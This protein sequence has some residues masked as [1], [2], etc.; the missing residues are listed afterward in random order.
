[1]MIDERARYGRRLRRLRRSARRWSVAAGVLGGASVVLA[2]Y[3]GLSPIDAFWVGAAGGSVV[4]AGWRWV[5]YREL[6]AQPAPPTLDPAAVADRARGWA[7][8]FV[9][10]LPWGREALSGVRRHANRGRLRGSAV[11]PGWIRL[12][13]AAVGLGGLPLRAGEPARTVVLDAAAAEKGLR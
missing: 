4:L 11:K 9:V 5:D 2:P 6:A 7:E 1:V 13:R 12:D 8:A 3:S 10:G